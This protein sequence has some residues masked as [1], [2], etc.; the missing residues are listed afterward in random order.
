MIRDAAT[1]LMLIMG[2]FQQIKRTMKLK[3]YLMALTLIVLMLVM[4]SCANTPF[5][6]AE[7]PDRYLI[8]NVRLVDV[9]TGHIQ[10]DQQVLI[11]GGRIEAI[12]P[13]NITMDATLPVKDAEGAYLM[14]GL[15]DMH[16]HGYDPGAF[17]LTLSHGVTHV[18]VMNGTPEHVKWRA[19]QARGEL[20]A[21]SL[22]V[23][24]PIVHSGGDWPLSWRADTADQARDLVQEAKARGYDLL[25]AYGS[26]NAEALTA[27]IEEAELQGLAVTKHG[28]HPATDMPWEPLGTLQSL[29][30]VEDIYQGLLHHEHDAERLPDIA[31]QLHNL[32]VPITPTLN[33]YWQL[34]QLSDQKQAFIDSLPTDYIS[35]VIRYEDNNNQ[36]KR[37]LDSS[38]QM[39]AHNQRTFSFLQ[40]ITR[41][42]AAAGVEL[43]V[44][45]DSGVLLSPH[46]LA[47]VD[48]MRLMHEAG[49]D[50]L[51]V[52]QAATRNPAQALGMAGQLGLIQAGAQA[53]LLLLPGNPL[54]DLQALEAPIAVIKAGTWLD[55]KTLDD[56]RQS[57]IDQRNWLTELWLIL[58]N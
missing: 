50:N 46:G 28:P 53:D 22:T 15:I 48:E 19:Q 6:I 11:D 54:E 40:Q 45:S 13:M 17:Q 24:S 16:V 14:P 27:L 47:T 8:N 30:H 34:T 25:K 20:L 3:V 55:R 41:Q 12:L 43:L 38:T 51:T 49:L 39:A 9:S 18:R 1:Y 21:S 36:V 26:M 44:G 52:L 5:V 29:E 33:I 23:S 37:W 32:S 31:R 58:S 7:Q 56:L 42:L 2:F 4:A 35:P 10:T 57:A